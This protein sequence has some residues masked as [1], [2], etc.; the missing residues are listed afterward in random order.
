[1]NGRDLVMAKRMISGSIK[2]VL[3]QLNE[4]GKSASLEVDG[5]RVAV[6]NL[7]KELWP[8]AGRRRALTK[9]DLLRYYARV[10][11]WLLPHLAGRPLFATRFPNGIGGKSFFQKHWD[12]APPFARRVAIYSSSGDTDGEYLICENLATLLW[13]AQMGSLELHAWFSRVETGPDTRV[14]SRIFTGSE[15]ALERS[16]LNYPDFVVFDLD[17]YLY[18]GREARGAEPELNRKAFARTRTLAL[19]IRDLLDALDLATFI[20]TSGRTGLHLYLPIKR[21]LSYDEVREIAG[22]IARHVRNDHPREVTIEWSV[23]ARRGKIFFDFNQNSRGKS[24]ATPFSPRKHPAGTVSA[25]LWWE[26]LE[27]V[28][29]TDFTL[30]TMPDRL[31][32]DGDPWA[33]ILEAKQ[34]LH[35]VLEREAAV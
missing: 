6:S 20:K 34:D 23:S 18:S 5:Q 12:N 21:E 24:V 17:P 1:V 30:L 19:R 29:P 31:E 27:K 8:A 32:E 11:P 22:T 4:A 35:P 26:E 33:G 3:D 7:D 25:T 14:R 28:Y 13:L 16:I 10:S 15:A 9:R 2:H